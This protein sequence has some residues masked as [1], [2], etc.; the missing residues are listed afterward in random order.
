MPPECSVKLFLLLGIAREDGTE[1]MPHIPRRAIRAQRVQQL[2]QTQMMIHA[3][4]KALTLQFLNERLE[5]Q[6]AVCG[7]ALR[8]WFFLKTGALPRAVTIHPFGA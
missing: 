3:H 7:A 5:K 6:I 2:L 4:D 1:Q 8:Q